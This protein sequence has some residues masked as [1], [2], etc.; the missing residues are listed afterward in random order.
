[1]ASLFLSHSTDDDPVAHALEAWLRERQITDVIV[2]YGQ[3]RAQA[4]WIDA[5]NRA[6]GRCR[7]VVCLVTEAWLASPEA[8]RQFEI[9][10]SL[11]FRVLPL[12]ALTVTDRTNAATERLERLREAAQGFDLAKAFGGVH[13]ID[14]S[15]DR[16][17][18]DT[19]FAVLRAAGADGDRDAYAFDVDQATC[20]TPFPGL[21]AFGDTDADAALFFGRERELTEVLQILR[22]MR[23]ADDR[24]VLAILG[25]SGVGKSS[26]VAAGIVPRLRNEGGVWLPLRVFRPGPRPLL[27]FSE[28]LTRTLADHGVKESPG[29]LSEDLQ[30][31]W[32]DA[33]RDERGLTLAG[34]EAVAAR[35][36]TEIDRLRAAA[37]RASATVVITVDESE[38]LTGSE[39]GADAL[40][41]YLRAAID[42][43]ARV[44]MAMRSDRFGELQ[45]HHDFEGIEFR[46]YDLRPLSP[47]QIG[48]IIEEPARRYGL[49]VEPDLIQ[50]LRAD[51]K[52]Q[53]ALPPLAFTLHRLWWKF[54]AEGAMSATD[55]R[56]LGDLSGV[57]ESAADRALRGPSSGRTPRSTTESATDALGARA[58]VPALVRLDDAGRPERRQAP[59]AN[60]DDDEQVL[61]N[62]FV[63]VGLVQKNDNGTAELVHDAV[64]AHWL[65]LQR[66]LEDERKQR[67]VWQDLRTAAWAWSDTGQDHYIAHCGPKLNQVK[68][69]GAD[70]RYA[71]SFTAVERAYIEACE[72]FTK[73]APPSKPRRGGGWMLA[74][75]VALVA[76]VVTGASVVSR[77]PWLD[78]GSRF[79]MALQSSNGAADSSNGA[80]DA[81]RRANAQSYIAR[82][83]KPFV[84]TEAAAAALGAGTAF[85]ECKKDCPEMV[86]V[87]GGAFTMGDRLREWAFAQPTRRVT[88]S[89]PFAVSRT[90][91]TFDE[92]ATCVAYG[93]CAEA[94]DSGFGGG[95]RPVIN[96]SW[97][98]AR[99]YVQWLAESTGQP[100]RL[101]S[102]SEWE[103]AARAGTITAYSWGRRFRRQRANCRD[104]GNSE[105]GVRTAT[106]AAFA[107][108]PFG[109]Y[110]VHGNVWEWVED[111][112]HSDFKG[113]PS[114]G[115]AWTEA[116]NGDCN[117]ATVR[118]GAW[119][120]SR[121]LIRSAARDWYAKDER[122]N[123]VG[124]RVA[125]A[126]SD[127]AQ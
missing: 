22:V 3:G 20:E 65:R 53:E 73:P 105:A 69:L 26:L 12:W 18:A 85:R 124:F 54:S 30:V 11:G 1:M 118:G 83:V 111:C 114:D 43:G 108:N 66:W 9:A 56:S 17:A 64:I 104:C 47:D 10:S 120:F 123:T 76:G 117:K 96:V 77:A 115:S 84:L 112:W 42:A 92:W 95:S 45:R 68:A 37:G 102:E 46:G 90:E 27:S 2:A 29:V 88:I 35:F 59:W 62:R 109:L 13:G 125:R 75:A 86:V 7:L 79:V 50:A 31:A 34:R 67:G 19:L 16:V 126:L 36:A 38:A 8:F 91:V 113:A 81:V 40:A 51:F 41:D 48:R 6:A 24:R 78:V 4:T 28:A 14:F 15:M 127:A 80:A 5:L 103:Y 49:D 63:S 52:Q 116:E 107:A 71:A 39:D 25:A 70:P 106:V 89:K 101:L 72:A 98:D 97:N 32:A 100:Y 110:D 60:F 44:L 87:P 33:P 82:Y 58:F 23:G 99:A 74:A 94:S 121:N 61:L 57:L 119:D 93:S 21:A 55:Y 122:T